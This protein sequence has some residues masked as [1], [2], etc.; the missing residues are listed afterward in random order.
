MGEQNK[1]RRID[2]D[3]TMDDIDA[4]II[5][6][7][8]RGVDVT[9]IYSPVRVAATARTFGLI[10]YTIRHYSGLG[11]HDRGTQKEGMEEY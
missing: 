8:L 4:K 10:P 7:A 1:M 2:E 5:A 3:Q 9:E 11:L 6:S